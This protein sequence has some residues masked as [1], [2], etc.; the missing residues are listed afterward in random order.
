M[1]RNVI[2]AT[3]CYVRK[4]R[5]T[6]MLYRNKKKNDIHEGKWNGLGGK[7]L[8]GESPE[9]C[10]IREVKEESGLSLQEPYLRGHITFPEFDGVNDWN[11]FI[12]TTY[13]YK[14]SLIDSHEGELE[15]INDERILQLNLWPG[16]RIFLKWLYNEDNNFFSAKFCYEAGKLVDH[17]VNFYPYKSEK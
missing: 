1:N 7:F 6:L 11:V 17:K 5:Q 16:D 15:W 14:G 10:V 3:L 2:L 9:E 8:P 4:D 13:N 12:F